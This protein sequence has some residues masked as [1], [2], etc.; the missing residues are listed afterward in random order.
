MRRLTAVGYMR[1]DENLESPPTSTPI[2]SALPREMETSQRVNRTE[3]RSGADDEV[4]GERLGRLALLRYKQGKLGKHGLLLSTANSR[5]RA[6][7]GRIAE[8]AET[9]TDASSI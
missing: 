2:I 6:A 9:D 1:G 8:G 7:A 5:Q 3:P 4:V